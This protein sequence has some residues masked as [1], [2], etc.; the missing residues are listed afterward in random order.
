M[1]KKLRI[2]FLGNFA[3]EKGSDVFKEVVKNLSLNDFEFYIFGY[4]GDYQSFNEIK[5]KIKHVESYTYGNLANL[6]KKN[7][8]DLG[9]CPSLFPETFHK[10]FFEAI[11]LCDIIIPFYCFPAILNP[12]YKLIIKFK[13]KNQMIKNIIRLVNKYK[14]SSEKYNHF[15]SKKM[16]V[17]KENNLKI[18]KIIEK[19]I[20]S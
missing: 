4:I 20:L 11:N 10:V 12:K 5:D 16:N 13:T 1:K 6:V 7:K 14:E 2:A 9:I 15:F 18:A 19:E 17:L 8:I 3:K